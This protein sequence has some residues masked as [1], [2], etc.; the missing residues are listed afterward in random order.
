MSKNSRYDRGCSYRRAVHCDMEGGEEEDKLESER[1][2]S[3]S[4]KRSQSHDTWPLRLYLEVGI[5][6]RSQGLASPNTRT[7]NAQNRYIL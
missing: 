7:S 1:F 3:D 4:A 6:E 5:A 2:G